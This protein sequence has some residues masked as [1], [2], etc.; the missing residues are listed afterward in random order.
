M[1]QWQRA[2]CI[3]I[4]CV[5]LACLSVGRAAAENVSVT[6]GVGDTALSVAGQTSPNAFVTIRKDGGVIGTAS[7]DAAGIYS[8]LFSAQEPGLHELSLYAHTSGDNIT[9]TVTLSVNL[10]EHATTSVE[11]FLPSTLVLEDPTLE[12][13]QPLKISGEAA[14]SSTITIYID[15][16]DYATTTTD[17]QGLWATSLDTGPLASGR[18]Q[19]FVRVTDAYG[20]QSYPTAPRYF[21][22]AL[23]QPSSRT[24]TTYSSQI[25][26]QASQAKLIPIVTFPLVAA[27]IFYFL[28][29]PQFP[30]S[31]VTPIYYIL[32]LLL[33]AAAARIIWLM[34]KRLKKRG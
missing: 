4:L 31:R 13:S 2:G 1:R 7:A 32:L 24:S 18:H 33:L 27:D 22:R 10:V 17:A 21:S 12:N 11:V 34:I 23:S 29:D 8:Q 16:T 6:I 28:I 30:H 14:P 3:L 9:D 26:P 25:I 15:N 19:L 20:N 5:T